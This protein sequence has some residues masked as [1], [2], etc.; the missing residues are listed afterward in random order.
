MIISNISRYQS[1]DIKSK[2]MGTKPSRPIV[3][4]THKT[5]TD[6]YEASSVGEAIAQP[7]SSNVRGDLIQTVKKRIGSGYYN[8]GEVLED[9]STSFAKAL[10]QTL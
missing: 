6:T 8:S 5:K 1:S 2:A 3:S 9:L 10:N 7:S 4:K